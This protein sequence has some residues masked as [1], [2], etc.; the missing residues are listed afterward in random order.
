LF[1]I[2]LI[3][4]YHLYEAMLFFQKGKIKLLSNRNKENHGDREAF[5]LK[6]KN[7]E[8]TVL[9]SCRLNNILELK[10]VFDV[11]WYLQLK[12]EKNKVRVIILQLCEQENLKSYDV[13]L[14]DWIVNVY[15]PYR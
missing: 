7:W 3:F 8:H 9:M 1:Q 4:Y 5:T 13:C 14:W 12:V 2:Q 11:L 6:K 10:S 15:I